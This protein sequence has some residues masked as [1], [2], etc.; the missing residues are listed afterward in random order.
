V[1]RGDYTERSGFVLEN[2]DNVLIRGFTVRDFGDKPVTAAE[3]GSGSLVY[4]QNA[5]Y[6][7]IEQNRLV[8]GDQSGILLADSA[9]T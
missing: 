3:W 6:N 7:R 2:V 5:H 9:T 1:L 8:N 4:L